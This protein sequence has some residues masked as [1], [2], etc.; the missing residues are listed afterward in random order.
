MLA[1]AEAGFED[2]TLNYLAFPAVEIGLRHPRVRGIDTI[3]SRVRCLTG[4]LL[5]QCWRCDTRTAARWSAS[6]ARSRPPSRG[7][8]WTINF[9]D[10]DGHLLDYR[11]VEDLAGAERI[12]LRHRCFGNRARRGRRGFDV[13]T[14]CPLP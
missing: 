12:S 9:Y 5:E 2:G 6:T 4:W 14:T 13:R 10:P 1:P 7:G 3:E 11:R 8:R